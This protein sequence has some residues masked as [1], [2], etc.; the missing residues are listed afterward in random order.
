MLKVKEGNFVLNKTGC[1]RRN[2]LGQNLYAQE[3]CRFMKGNLWKGILS[4]DKI[5]IE[6]NFKCG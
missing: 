2:G 4:A 1:L 3:S 6:L 5:E